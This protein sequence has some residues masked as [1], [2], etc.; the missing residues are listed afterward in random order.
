MNR[1]IEALKQESTWRGLIAIAAA[2]GIQIH[3]D[4]AASIITVALSLIGT[5]N[6]VKNK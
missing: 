3:P 2:F 6:I 5:I 4:L 1:I